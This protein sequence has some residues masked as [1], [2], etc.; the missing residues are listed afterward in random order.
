[1]SIQPGDTVSRHDNLAQRL[2]EERMLVITAQDSM[3]HRFNEVGTFI[4][5]LL[6]Q[7]K[8]VGEISGALMEHFDGV[9]EKKLNADVAAFLE[10]LRRKNLID[11]SPGYG[12][13]STADD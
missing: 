12:P 7:P 8:T 2:F 9:D 5:Q 13:D 1:M 3:L 10:E 4:W 11:I 6:D